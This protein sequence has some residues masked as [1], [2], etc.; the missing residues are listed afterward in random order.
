VV[1]RVVSLFSRQAFFLL[2]A[3][4]PFICDAQFYS[5]PTQ[6]D[7]NILT[8]RK[9]AKGDTIV[10]PGMQPYIPLLNPGHHFVAD[11][12]VVF[13][14]IKDDAGLDAVFREHLIRVKPKNEPFLLRIDPVFN[15]EG[16]RDTRD[17]TASRLYT[18]SRGFVASGNIGS[19]FYFESMLCENQSFFPSYLNTESAVTKVVPGQ[20][21]WKTFKGNGF[22]YAFV[23]GIAS[24][25]LF[26]NVNLQVGHGKHKV[27]HGYRS[28]LLSDNAFNYP[29]V[30]LTQQWF[31]GRLRYTNVYASFM[32]LVPAAKVVT[33]NTEP[34]FQK[35]SAAFQ[36][37]EV[38]L[39]PAFTLSFF[40]GFVWKAADDK[41]RQHLTW[42]Y[43]NPVIYSQLIRSGL[44][45]EEKNIVAGVD[46][47]LKVSSKINVYGQFMAD[48]TNDGLGYQLGV[49][50]FDVF[51]ISHLSIQGEYNRVGELAYSGTVSPSYFH[52][53]QNIAFTP[54]NCSEQIYMLDYRFKRMVFDVH[55]HIQD[56]YSGARNKNNI[57]NVKLAYL[58]NP[59]Y[60]MQLGGG[61]MGRRNNY[62]IGVPNPY[63]DYFYL[64]FKTSIYNQYYDF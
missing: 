19:R 26:S 9:L 1:A 20:G 6:Y 15:F 25:Q 54:Q 46:L 10:H 32:N 40:Q 14:Y 21:R 52:Y 44:N 35:K 8:T 23:S 24:I 47:L 53:N 30:R 11:T 27:G 60:N 59:R 17:T 58:V 28:L 13:K 2:C 4:R 7:Y 39:H 29:F 34:L 43:F 55:Y 49:K 16:G 38:Q 5:L 36:Y 18:N 31:K 3:A 61:Y 63:T 45:D 22:D 41:N 12:S 37:L 62:N 51:G 42:E 48:N 50:Y 57:T 33:K 64:S 56:F